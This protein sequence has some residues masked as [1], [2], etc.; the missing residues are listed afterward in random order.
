M[1]YLGWGAEQ[2]KILFV[3]GIPSK[4]DL[5]NGKILSGTDGA[6]LRKVLTAVNVDLANEVAYTSIFHSLEYGVKP[7][8][9]I[10]REAIPEVQAKIRGYNPEVVVALGDVAV[11][12][13]MGR[14]STISKN[15]GH[16]MKWEDTT[17]LASRHPLDVIGNPDE[18]PDLIL[19]VETAIGGIFQVPVPYKDYAMVD[20]EEMFTKMINTISKAKMIAVDIETTDL[21]PAVGSI[22]SIGLSH[23]YGTAW[24]IDGQWLNLVNPKYRRGL[25][26]ILEIKSNIY[27]NAQFDV[28]WMRSRGFEINLGM[29]TM[30][31]HYT[32]D[33][34]QDGHG[35]KRLATDQ[36]KAP[37]YDADLDVSDLTLEKWADPD[38]RKKV[39]MYNG[40]DADYTYRLA[41]DLRM[42]MEADGVASVHDDILVP[43]VT[44]FI[45]LK[46]DGM[47]VDQ[48]YHDELGAAWLAEIKEIETKLRS[49][50]GAEKMNFRSTKQIKE[51]LYDTLGLIPMGG[52]KNAGLSAAMIAR[53]TRNVQDEE[54][55]EFWR[56]NNVAKNTKSSST[57]TYMLYYLAQQ[58]EFPR[59][60]TR[61]RVLSKLHGTYYEGYRNLMDER[62]RICPQYKLYGARTGRISSTKPNIHGMP[63]MNELKKI[64]IADPG[65]TII[66]ADY[67]Q[68]EIRMVAH[69]AEDESLIAAL[70]AQ[71]IHR[72]ISKTMFGLTD[73]QL[74]ALPE[75]ARAI[76]RRA[77]KTI[78]FGMV[79]G[80]GVNSVA[81]QLGIPVD[82]AQDY[83]DR[84]YAMMPKVKAWLATQKR[85]V[86]TKH[87][88]TSLYGRKRRFPL[89]SS[90]SHLA[91]AQRQAGN[92]PVQSAV[93]DMTILAG[94]RIIKRLE[95]QDVQCMIWPH[96]HDCVMFQVPDEF[97]E[98]AV[99][100]TIKEMHNVGF[101][102]NVAFKCEVETGKS[103]GDLVVKFNG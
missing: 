4:M 85:L 25:A 20:S 1:D 73:E 100:I 91:S 81:A 14:T 53:A 66:Y 74:D 72:E 11:T 13:L 58:H 65:H 79:Y 49:Y 68:A 9:D 78:A 29:D 59:L 96:I 97:T 95:D 37:E 5:A 46:E 92:M 6:L 30:L 62:G 45:R 15:R 101:K 38:F 35:L 8:I 40:A 56:T 42:D 71:D 21:D 48:A 76:K 32:L 18:F 22:L 50:P 27:H 24:V 84:F 93:S 102:T 70:D 61:H 54:A 89:I 99:K 23:E 75:E 69:L 47:L 86:S 44:H 98:H 26:D 80:R 33:G 34:R 63:R 36:Y 88:V 103:W 90:K 17:I 82:E 83:M 77:A 60:L 94:M 2:P 39:M 64:F 43:A 16:S 19:D 28:A 31:A 87:E 51:Y 67:S 7:K 41:Q 55:Q 52:K 57:G 10:I 3:A 12:A